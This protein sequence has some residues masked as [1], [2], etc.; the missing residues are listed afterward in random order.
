MVE[1]RRFE[2]PACGVKRVSVTLVRKGMKKKKRKKHIFTCVPANEAMAAAGLARLEG[3]R[4]VERWGFEGPTCGEKRSLQHWSEKKR[5]KRKKKHIFPY[6][7]ANEAMA[8]ARL[9]RLE[10]R[11][12]VERWGFEAPA[13]GKRSLSNGQKRNEKKKKKNITLLACPRV[14]AMA[15]VGVGAK[16]KRQQRRGGLRAPRRG[17]SRPSC[18]GCG[19]GPR[20]VVAVW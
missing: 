18:V 11:G 8:A 20:G 7:P 17:C 14:Q 6:V 19:D 16:G 1:R 3:R 10:G 12:M 2:D 5:K 13:C 4:T 15:A 9:A